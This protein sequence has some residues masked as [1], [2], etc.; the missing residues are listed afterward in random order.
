MVSISH[1]GYYVSA[2]GAVKD[3]S[4]TLRDL[5]VANGAKMMVVGSTVTDVM[6]VTAPMPGD[7]K[8]TEEASGWSVRVSQVCKIS[9]QTGCACRS[10]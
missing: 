8:Q 10:S 2:V 3:D 7:L 6:T 9:L 5:R 4:K 1:V